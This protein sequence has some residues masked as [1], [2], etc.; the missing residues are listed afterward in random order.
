LFLLVALAAFVISRLIFHVP[1]DRKSHYFPM[2]LVR[3]CSDSECLLS[4]AAA[5]RTFPSDF[6]VPFCLSVMAPLGGTWPA[7][8]LPHDRRARHH[9]VTGTYL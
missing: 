8:R 9:L 1:V 7:G 2:A 3:I 6:T 4:L 5:A